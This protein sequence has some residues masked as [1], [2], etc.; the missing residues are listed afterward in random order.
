[1]A[2]AH[3]LVP[4]VDFYRTLAPPT[5]VRQ[6]HVASAQRRRYVTELLPALMG[7]D[8]ANVCK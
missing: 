4:C 6:A 7:K 2:A 1:M 5:R 8:A 3:S